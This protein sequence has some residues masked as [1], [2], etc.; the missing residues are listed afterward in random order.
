ME[1]KEIIELFNER[2]QQAI[3]KTAEKYGNYCYS[4][5][6][7]ILA[8][9]E[10]CEECVNDTYMKAWQSIP[11][12]YP[13]ILSAYLGRITRNLSL[14]KY[15]SNSA[16]K[17]GGSAQNLIF[18]ELKYCLRSEATD[19]DIDEIELTELINNFLKSLSEEKRKI[20]VRRYWYFSS[21]QEISEFYGIT[22]SKVKMTLHRTR[23]KFRSFLEKEEVSI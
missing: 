2:N 9:T 7:N 18:E 15:R 12:E 3:S 19:K 11:P 21:I 13:R 17:R 14:N 1:D 20:F 16:E 5:S 4:I 8:N 6:Y 23:E 22:E 10:D